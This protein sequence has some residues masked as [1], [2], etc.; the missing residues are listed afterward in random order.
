M[1]L[2]KFSQILGKNIVSPDGRIPDQLFS[3]IT[4]K[5]WISRY[6]V[7]LTVLSLVIVI[8]PIYSK[9]KVIFALTSEYSKAKSQPSIVQLISLSPLQ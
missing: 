2:D 4:P 6:I 7:I 3:D 8:L 5:T 1:L 9:F